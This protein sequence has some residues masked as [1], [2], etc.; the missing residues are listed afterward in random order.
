MNSHSVFSTFNV[1][2]TNLGKAQEKPRPVMDAPIEEE[3]EKNLSEANSE[4][5]DDVP[6]AISDPV[7]IE[8]F[9]KKTKLSHIWQ[10]ETAQYIMKAS[11]LCPKDVEVRIE[12]RQSMLNSIGS[13][14]EQLAF[15]VLAQ[16]Q[17][18]KT[19]KFCQ[20]LL[21]QACNAPNASRLA[22]C[23]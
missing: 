12:S 15:T 10:V 17:R 18:A 2:R 1:S 14:D 22:Y 20:R 16:F 5:N 19:S 3:S 8:S 21:S 9:W 11:A 13:T 4:D 6:R 7:K 23:I